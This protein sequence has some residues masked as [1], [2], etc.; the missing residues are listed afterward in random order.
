MQAFSNQIL[1]RLKS[2]RRTSSR[3]SHVSDVA[4]SSSKS[5]GSSQLGLLEPAIINTLS[6]DQCKLWLTLH[7]IEFPDD[8]NSEE[9]LRRLVCEHASGNIRPASKKKSFSSKG[10]SYLSPVS[11]SL[12]RG[13]SSASDTKFRLKNI[14]VEELP[15]RALACVF[16]HLS[17]Q[18]YGKTVTWGIGGAH[19]ALAEVSKTFLKAYYASIEKLRIETC[20]AKDHHVSSFLSKCGANLSHL[21]LHQC[22]Y[23]TDATLASMQVYCPQM[24]SLEIIL[25]K[26]VLDAGIREFAES[27]G[28]QVRK[29]RLSHCHLFTDQCLESLGLLC[30]GLQEIH[31]QRLP[32]DIGDEGLSV[33]LEGAGES[34][35]YF[36]IDHCEGVS[37]RSLMAGSVYCSSLKGICLRSLKK[38]TNRGVIALTDKVGHRLQKLDL[39]KSANITDMTL[40]WVGKRNTKL[41]DVRLA[42]LYLIGDEGVCEMCE[43]L[44][45]SLKYLDISGNANI[46]DTAL[47]AIG[48]RNLD[49]TELRASRVSKITDYGVIS[50]CREGASHLQVLDISNDPHISPAVFETIFTYNVNLEILNVSGKNKV[51]TRAIRKFRDSVGSRFKLISHK[52]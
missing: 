34:L 46:T 3:R 12:K 19:K 32:G 20:T 22:P 41:R 25:M 42:D 14:N 48:R 35:R 2:T 44:G 1:H 40:A 45:D 24:K 10:S 16:Q 11:L 6:A 39:S 51:S 13:V 26:R 30:P 27:Y 17:G 38:I 36:S 4:L 21:I 29:I 33:L 9:E 5:C 7:Q 31:L 43:Q 50:L 15:L 18:R 23:I 8:C 47:V 49:L 37:D 52:L 28:N